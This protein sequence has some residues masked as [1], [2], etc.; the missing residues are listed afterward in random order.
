MSASS[1]ITPLSLKERWKAHA[2]TLG[3]CMFLREPFTV[4]AAGDAGYDSVC[5]DIQHGL[6]DYHDTVAML[7]GLSRT[8]ATPIVRVPWNEPVVAGIQGSAALTETRVN[9]GFQMITV[10]HDQA[11]V[12]TALRTDLATSRSAVASTQLP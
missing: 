2:T 6:A 7:Q 10:G 9:Q 1:P 3:A 4:E 5:V 11:P 12:V 8:P